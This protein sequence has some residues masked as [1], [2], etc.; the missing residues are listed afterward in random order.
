[1]ERVV[2]KASSFVEAEA[3]DVVQHR[4]MTPAERMRAGKE[5]RDRVF[6]GKNPDIKEWHR[7]KN[8][9]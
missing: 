1:V 7:K 2:H 8:G 9:I 3:W 5:I 6:P 4:E